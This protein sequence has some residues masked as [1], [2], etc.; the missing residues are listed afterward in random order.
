MFR[1][2]GD[3]LVYDGDVIVRGL[4]IRHLVLPNGLAESEKVFQFIA[5]ELSPNVFISLMSQ[6][7]PTNKSH[8]EIL[9]DRTLRLSEYEKTLE[10]MDKYGLYNGWVQKMES[11]NNYR[12]DFQ[13]DRKNPFEKWNY[14]T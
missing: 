5:K 3:K 2:V 6:Y 10:L 8:K 4:I 9:L 13:K 12:P 7:Y 14:D 11:F 1:Q